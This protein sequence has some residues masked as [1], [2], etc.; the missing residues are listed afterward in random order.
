MKTLFWMICFDSV[1]IDITS[2]FRRKLSFGSLKNCDIIFGL[3]NKG[4]VYLNLPTTEISNLNNYV[5]EGNWRLKYCEKKI[6]FINWVE[7]HS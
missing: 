7:L 4:Y 3:R 1:Q 5:N 6:F 2:F